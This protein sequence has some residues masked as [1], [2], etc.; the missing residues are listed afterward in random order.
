[1][2]FWGMD[3]ERAEKVA[4]GIASQIFAV[5]TRRECIEKQA[6]STREL[7]RSIV[8]LVVIALVVGLGVIYWP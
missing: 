5:R 4:D 6:R 2:E 8:G 7:T 1:M 3:R